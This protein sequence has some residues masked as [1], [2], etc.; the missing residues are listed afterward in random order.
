MNNEDAYFEEMCRNAQ[1]LEIAKKQIQ[2]LQDIEYNHAL[3]ENEIMKKR[4]D[5]LHDQI[6][7]LPCVV[8]VRLMTR[9]DIQIYG[10][11]YVTARKDAAE[12]VAGIMAGKD[13]E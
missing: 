13:E 4:L 12:L 11:G 6:M 8:P 5:R 2:R 3:K 1:E 7:N 10:W 9:N